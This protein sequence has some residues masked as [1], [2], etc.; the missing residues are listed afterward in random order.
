VNKY[1]SIFSEENRK[2]KLIEGEMRFLLAERTEAISSTGS[3]NGKEQEAISSTESEK[4]K[5]Q[6]ASSS[7]ESEN[8]KEQ[9]ADKRDEAVK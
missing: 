1:L 7:I 3:K 6:E 5:E 4:G 2:L 8:G 9:D